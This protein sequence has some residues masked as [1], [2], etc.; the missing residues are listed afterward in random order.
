MDFLSVTKPQHESADAAHGDSACEKPARLWYSYK[1]YQKHTEHNDQPDWVPRQNAYT[2]TPE[3]DDL[4]RL[5]VGVG[6]VRVVF[7]SA[8]PNIRKHSHQLSYTSWKHSRQ[9]PEFCWCT[10]PNSR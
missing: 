8:A 9:V 10:K 6:A 4:G 3:R 1:A 7:A 5:R 2:V